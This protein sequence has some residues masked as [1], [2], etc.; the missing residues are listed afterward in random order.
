MLRKKTPGGRLPWLIAGSLFLIGL[1]VSLLGTAV[2]VRA[3]GHTAVQSQGTSD[4][5]AKF[6][7][8][9]SVISPLFQSRIDQQVPTAVNAAINS[10]VAKLPASS[11][12]WA[13]QMAQALIQPSANLTSITPQQNGLALTLRISLYPGDPQPITSNMLVTFGVKDASTIQVSGQATKN[14][15][16][17]VN[18]PLATFHMPVGQLSSVQTTPGCGDAALAVGLSFPISLSAGQGSTPT[19]QAYTT[20]THTFLSQE[21]PAGTSTGYVEI[22]ASSVAML[23][24][25]MGTIPVSSNIN[26]TNIRVA[27]QGSQMVVTSDID[28]GSFQIGTATTLMTPT[29]SNGNL[30]VTVNQTTLNV[31]IMQFQYNSYNQQIQQMINTKLSGALNGKFTV[32]SA[33]IGTNS[34]V[35]CAASDSLILSGSSSLV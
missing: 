12:S 25:S 7:L 22:P 21:V 14:G 6:Y 11:Q 23:G 35:P 32:N 8:P 4:I 3:A 15:L 18:G 1:I 16:T 34:H 29:A 2:P 30:A 10:I 17:L 13:Q 5:P 26:A 9:T 28:L 24:N 20:T 19:A 27:V 31:L 33:A